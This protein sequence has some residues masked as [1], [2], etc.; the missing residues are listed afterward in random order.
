MLRKRPVRL[1]ISFA[2]V[3]NFT[4][5]AYRLIPLNATTVGFALWFAKTPCDCPYRKF[6]SAVFNPM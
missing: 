2:A 3:A 5:V 4:F 1:L 6:H